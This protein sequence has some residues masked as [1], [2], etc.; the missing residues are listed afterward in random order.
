[1]LWSYGIA[2]NE[3]YKMT[4]KFKKLTPDKEELTV[5]CAGHNTYTV[6]QLKKEAANPKSEIGQKLQRAR[7]YFEEN[8][9]KYR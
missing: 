9:D 3:R 7:K 4:V 5:I 8:Q 2:I 1:M 6:E